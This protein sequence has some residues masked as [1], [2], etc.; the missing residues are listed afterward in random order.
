MADLV[1]P[2]HRAGEMIMK[3]GS[4]RIIESVAFKSNAI[5]YNVTDIRAK[6][7][8]SI[9]RLSI[10]KHELDEHDHSAWLFFINLERPD[11]CVRTSRPRGRGGPPAAPR[12]QKDH[13]LRR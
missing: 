1:I 7:Q 8:T 9:V 6:E 12:I 3:E 5:S 2:L 13:G 10:N 4:L 11:N